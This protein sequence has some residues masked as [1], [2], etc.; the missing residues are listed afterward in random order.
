MGYAMAK[1]PFMSK[2]R[3]LEDIPKRENVNIGLTSPKPEF[4]MKLL[5]PPHLN[6]VYIGRSDIQNPKLKN[7]MLRDS[8]GP[9]SV[10]GLRIAVNSLRDVL[11]E[12]RTSYPDLVNRLGTAGMCVVRYVGG[13][14]RLSNHS[15]GA[16]VDLMVDGIEDAMSNDKCEKGLGLMVQ[17]FNKHGWYWGGAYRPKNGKSNEDSMHFEVS[18][19]KLQEWEKVGAFGTGELIRQ[20]GTPTPNGLDSF[21]MYELLQRGSKGMKVAMLQG[22][23]KERSFSPDSNG[24]FGKKTEL[25]VIEFQRKNGL[26][27][28]GVVDQKTAAYLSLTYK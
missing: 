5:G 20:G 16:A 27:A 18:M 28:T 8:V 11:T 13:T 19:E 26:P 21:M 25:A 15:W 4:L 24:I 12:V 22:S 6:G 7:L 14:T 17:I 1:I 2:L 3:E 10:Y 9:F 23:L